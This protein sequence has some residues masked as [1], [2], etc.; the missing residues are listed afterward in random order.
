M[1]K[2]RRADDEESS[3]SELS[4]SDESDNEAKAFNEAVDRGMAAMGATASPPT[5]CVL[6]KNMFDPNG[7]DEKNDPEFFDDLMEGVK[8]ECVKYGTVADSKFQPESA[9][10]VYL[11]FTDVGGAAACVAALNNRWFAG[12]QI[13]AAHCTED[14]YKAA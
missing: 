10:H 2:R 11:M 8:E 12:K 3:P 6:V 1:S 14:E 9:G 7:E 5:T 13:S 4:S